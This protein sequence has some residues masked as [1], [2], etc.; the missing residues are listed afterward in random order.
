MARTN[1]D[2]DS[3]VHDAATG[4]VYQL[5]ASLSQAAGNIGRLRFDQ[6]NEVAKHLAQAGEMISLAATEV[7]GA[8]ERIKAMA[9]SEFSHLR[10][11]VG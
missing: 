3:A 9:P 4:V 6:E 7:Q 1:D 11:T 5:K 8:L 2:M 10:P